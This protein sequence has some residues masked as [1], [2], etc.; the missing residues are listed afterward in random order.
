MGPVRGSNPGASLEFESPP[1]LPGETSSM[2]SDPAS[3]PQR[4]LLALGDDGSE[5]ADTA[6]RWISSHAW[7]GWHIDVLTAEMDESRVEWGKPPLTEEWTPAWPRPVDAVTGAATVRFRK[8]VTDP[9][10][11]LADVEAD[12][13]VVGVRS[14][15]YLDALVTGSTT[16]WLLHHPPAPLLVARVDDE[17]EKVLVCADGSDHASHAIRSFCALPLAKS[18]AVAVVA[19]DDGRVDVD[20]ALEEAAGQLE[21]NVASVAVIRSQGS[22]PR[23]ILDVLESEAPQLAVLGT[24]GLTG[25]QRLRLGST[26]AAVVR[27]AR[28]NS[29]VDVAGTGGGEA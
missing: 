4:P 26:A 24:R 12:L 19:V 3:S 28:C 7:P 11:M 5:P 20:A 10:A 9:R 23:Q 14:G 27:A 18:A 25:W 15:G 13:L 29:L 22:P 2:S 1:R 8:V 21:G 6:W 16:E 17:V